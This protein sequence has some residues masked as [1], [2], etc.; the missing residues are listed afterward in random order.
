MTFG[1]R[2]ILGKIR[3]DTSRAHDDMFAKKLLT[4]YYSLLSLSRSQELERKK[5]WSPATQS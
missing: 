5:W 1:A 4:S 3:F 2:V